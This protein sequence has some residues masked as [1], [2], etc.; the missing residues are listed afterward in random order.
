MMPEGLKINWS[1]LN[2]SVVITNAV[3]NLFEKFSKGTGGINFF[4]SIA[5]QVLSRNTKKYFYKSL[6]QKIQFASF[7]ESIGIT[8][9]LF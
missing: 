3:G 8:L 9:A 1:Y 2:K 6:T 4:P 5:G 7:N